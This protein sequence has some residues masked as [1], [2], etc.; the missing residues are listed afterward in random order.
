M[1]GARICFCFPFPCTHLVCIWK[2]LKYSVESSKPWVWCWLLAH[3]K[4]DWLYSTLF[5]GLW[6][7]MSSVFSL[8]RNMNAPPELCHVARE[9][10]REKESANERFD[11][12]STGEWDHS[13][14]CLEFNSDRIMQHVQCS[15]FNAILLIAFI[16]VMYITAVLSCSTGVPYVWFLIQRYFRY[17]I[18]RLDHDS[19]CRM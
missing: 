13:H 8:Y 2:C 11:I 14:K 10:E 16:Q 18:R 1:K 9:R 19:R 4:P 7:L 12:F 6:M 17:T 15:M 3:T 5:D